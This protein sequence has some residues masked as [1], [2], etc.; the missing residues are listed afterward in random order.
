MGLYGDIYAED[1]TTIVNGYLP[2][3]RSLCGNPRPEV[4]SD[5]SIT[6]ARASSSEIVERKTRRSEVEH[7]GNTLE[8]YNA[9]SQAVNLYS[10]VYLMAPFNDKV[11]VRKMNFTQAEQICKDIMEAEEPTDPQD[12]N[13]PIVTGDYATKYLAKDGIGDGYIRVSNFSGG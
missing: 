7:S 11:E 4:M 2:S 8:L 13:E 3:I 12:P 5:S 6:A 9:M 10:S 1:G